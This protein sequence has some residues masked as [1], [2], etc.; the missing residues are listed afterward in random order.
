VC[1]SLPVTHVLSWQ[2]GFRI[3]RCQSC[4]LS[5]RLDLPGPDE[6]DVLYRSGFYVPAPPRGG[7]LAR[8]LHLLSSAVRLRALDGIAPGRLLDVGS[9]KGAFLA[10]ARD[11]GWETLGVE[12]APEAAEAARAAF[13]VDVIVENFLDVRELGTFDLVTMWH[14]LEHL[15]DPIGALA[16]AADCLNP[17]GRLLVSVPN[18]ESLQARLGGEDW[19]HLDL[20]RHLFHF[21]PRSLT[22][23]VERAGFRVVRI[24]YLYP[25]VEVIGLLQTALNRLGI[26]N[27]L[28]YR[29]AKRDPA[30]RL[31]PGVVASLVLALAMAPAA[32]AWAAIAPALRTGASMQLIAE[33]V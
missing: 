25:E 7:R 3:A 10:A 4:G 5:W 12:Y 19:F 11:A 33:R 24:S 32:L 27:D 26:E 1:G 9:G 2:H 28:L 18:L 30:A 22:T 29:F 17:G 23:L 21:T 15:T 8:K 16:R 13:G 14:V 20:P 31:G 6:L